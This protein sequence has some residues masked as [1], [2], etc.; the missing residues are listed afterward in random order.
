MLGCIDPQLVD[1]STCGK[2]PTESAGMWQCNVI[3]RSDNVCS[4]GPQIERP[5]SLWM[6]LS[7][8]RN[9]TLAINSGNR[10]IDIQWLTVQWL[11]GCG[12]GE[13]QWSVNDFLTYTFGIQRA[14]SSHPSKVKIFVVSIDKK[15]SETLV[16]P[17][18]KW[19]SMECQRFLLLHL[20]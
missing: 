17:S 15:E 3:H 9:D 16:T 5:Q 12:H 1:G 19:G 11:L 10:M 14:T 13:R 18:L 8:H 4:I 6:P 20:A 2:L 7:I